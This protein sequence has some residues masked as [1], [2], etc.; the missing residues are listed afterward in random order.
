MT[1]CRAGHGRTAGRIDSNHRRKNWHRCLADNSRMMRKKRKFV[2]TPH[3]QTSHGL[4]ELADARRRPHHPSIRSGKYQEMAE[5][6]GLTRECTN[7]RPC[8]K[9]SE[10]RHLIR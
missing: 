5:T 6:E 8:T 1:S 10:N 9:A 3:K 2:R 4:D 7:A